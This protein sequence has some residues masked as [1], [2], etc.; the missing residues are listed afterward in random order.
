ME[1]GY[2]TRPGHQRLATERPG[3]GDHM[4]V[5]KTHVLVV[6]HE[7]PGLSIVRGGIASDDRILV[8]AHDR[9]HA[10]VFGSRGRYHPVPSEYARC[11]RQEHGNLLEG[12]ERVDRS[13][14]AGSRPVIWKVRPEVSREDWKAGRGIAPE[15]LSL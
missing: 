8:G 4:E 12:H 2:A 5:A 14:A 9:E 15:R 6:R 11:M 7:D 1:T 3:R 13:P 10:R